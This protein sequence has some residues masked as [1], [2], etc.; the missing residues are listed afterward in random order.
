M[1]ENTQERIYEGILD[2]IDEKSDISSIKVAEIAKR[3]GIGKGTVYEYCDSKEQLI[4]DAI[5]YMADKETKLIANSIKP[6]Q[7][8]KE[9]YFI[10]MKDIREIIKRN[11]T[12]FKYLAL[13]DCN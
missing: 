8:F 9:S 1:S 5:I 4:V 12:L 10:L 11:I 2:L 6:E 7:T 13:K 3:A